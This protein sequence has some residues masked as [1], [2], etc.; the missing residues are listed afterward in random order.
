[1][2]TT[3][4]LIAEQVLRILEGGDIND[5]SAYDIREVMRLIDQVV[6]LQIKAG[7]I[8]NLKA[9]HPGVAGSYISTFKNIPLHYDEDMGVSYLELPCNY[10]HLPAGRGIHH[11]SR[12]KEIS[13]AFVPMSSGNSS[14]FSHSPAEGLEGRIGFY[15]EGKRIYLTK[16]LY[17]QGC[18]KVLL[19]LVIP[20]LSEVG[21][22]DPYPIG[23]EAE[24]VVIE[25][26]LELLREPV[27][28]DVLNDNNPVR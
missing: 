13:E 10:V 6:S 16:D 7:W 8:E 3:K 4:K 12:T 20:P 25:K 21:Q 22:D 27:K 23:A 24:L 2:M 14:L 19:K 17:H 18:K 9:G 15:P 11:L 26:V 28:K 1:M 5:D